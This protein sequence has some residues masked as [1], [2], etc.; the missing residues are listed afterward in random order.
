MNTVP[1]M[2]ELLDLLGKKVGSGEV[3]AR[4][5]AFKHLR[6]EP[7]YPEPDEEPRRMYLTSKAEGIEIYRTTGGTI[8]TIFL[9]SEGKDE[10]SEYRGDLGHGLSFR[11][12]LDEVLRVHGRP[13]FS[14][15]AG[16][17]RWEDIAGASVRFD[18]PANCIHF[19]F[20]VDGNGIE[21]VTL[22]SPASLQGSPFDD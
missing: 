6:S 3:S 11:S 15:P 8:T 13:A 10:Y 19:Q 7:L 22:M 12:T 4:L 16:K 14:R 17:S 1:S 20:R 5:R 21:R 18:T 2:A 9:M